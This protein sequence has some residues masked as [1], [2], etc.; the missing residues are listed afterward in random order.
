MH[1]L[2]SIELHHEFRIESVRQWSG[3][4]LP[5]DR[6]LYERARLG[7]EELLGEVLAEL[8]IHERADRHADESVDECGLRHLDASERQAVLE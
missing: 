7:G 8:C 4:D 2:D 3:I 5:I 1:P 6:I